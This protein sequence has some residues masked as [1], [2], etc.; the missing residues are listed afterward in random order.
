MVAIL[1]VAAV[2]VSA[3][4]A[5]T[6][7]TRDVVTPQIVTT[8]PRQEQEAVLE[9]QRQHRTHVRHDG[10][11]SYCGSLTEEVFMAAV[12]S[13]CQM[14]P[15]D[16]NYK[17]YIEIPNPRAG[18]RRISG[19]GG[20]SV[21]G[22]WEKAELKHC[23]LARESGWSVESVR[24]VVERGESV[25]VDIEP[26]TKTAKFYFQHLSRDGRSQFIKAISSEVANVGNPGHFYV[27]PFFAQRK[28]D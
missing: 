12:M 3:I 7:I 27:V 6:H 9:V 20:K 8:C 2:L 15:T 14:T 21:S 4:I 24:R 1:V 25:L 18:R 23:T 11:C 10:T 19:M 16:K 22:N 17:V 26:A 5:A 28:T 13:G